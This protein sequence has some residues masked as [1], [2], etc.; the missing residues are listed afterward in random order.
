METLARH[1]SLLLDTARKLKLPVTKIYKEIVSGETIAARPVVQ[2]LIDE[3]E[4]GIWAGVLVV[5]IERLAR[6]DTIDQGIIA[7]AFKNH[8]TKIITP[9]KTYDPSNEFDEEYFEFGLF[10]SRREYKTIN[11]RIQRGRIAS[12]KEGKFISSTPPFGYDKI[13]SPD[14]KGFTLHPNADA[15]TVKY[16]YRSYADG[17]GMTVIA[18]S[19]DRMQIKTRTGRNW[20]KSTINDIL[21]NPVYIGKIRWSYKKETTDGANSKRRFKSDDYILVDG[22]HEPIVDSEMFSKVQ[23]NMKTNRM[24]PVKQDLMLKNPLTGLMHCKKCGAVMTRLGA[25]AHTP[26]DAVKCSNRYCDNVSAPMFLVEKKLVETLQEWL[27]RYI[28]EIKET[29]NKPYDK[30][31]SVSL[32]QV[33]SELE[34]VEKQIENTFDL[35]EQGIYTPEIFTQRNQTLLKRKFELSEAEAKINSEIEQEREFQAATD[36]I[37]PRIENIIK[38]YDTLS[39]AKEKNVLLKQVLIRIDYIK[40]SPNRKGQLYNDNFDIF[41]YP[42]VANQYL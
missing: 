30:P 17:S 29:D 16:I 37:I 42:K 21:K 38:V 24:H 39:D 12:A 2:Q 33:K 35:L 1:E 36:I 40:L 22:L 34:K 10:M 19:L 31:L 6:G 4:R 11:R 9:M 18:N 20:S 32:N 41:I 15:D 14:G 5:E 23:E 7:K 8:N 26:Y 25:N 28:I 13:K 3:V 27:N